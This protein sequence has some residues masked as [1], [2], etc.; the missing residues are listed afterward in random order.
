MHKVIHF[1]LPQASKSFLLKHGGRL[2]VVDMSLIPVLGG[3]HREVSE[4][5][6]SLGYIA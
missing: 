4:F 2:E 6:S 1:K 3:R 5:E